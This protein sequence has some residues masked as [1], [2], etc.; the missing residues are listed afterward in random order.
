MENMKTDS[1]N[2][3]RTRA[4]RSAV[5]AACVHGVLAAGMLGGSLT[6]GA[7]RQPTTAASGWSTPIAFDI[8]AQALETALLLFSQQARIQ[9]VVANGA[10]QGVMAPALKGEYSA[11]DALELLLSQSRLTYEVRDERTIAI[12]SEERVGF[13]QVSLGPEASRVRVAQAEGAQ[14]SPMSSEG[15]QDRLELEEIIVTGSH[16]RG[17]KV[18]VPMMRFTREEIDQA[19][20]STVED[21]FES[22]PQNLGEVS[23]AAAAGTGVSRI[24]SSNT[25]RA[26]GISLR[27][28][29]PESTLVLLNGKRR[30]GNINGQVFDISA[31]PLSVIERVEVVTGGRSA[32]YGADAV[33][34]VVNLTTRRAFNGAESQLYYGEAGEGGER[35]QASQIFG[36]EGERGGF[37]AAYDY[38]RDHVFDLVA[39]TDASH[40]PSRL[41][42]SLEAYSLI[43]DRWRHSGFFSGQYQLTENV[44]V[45]GDAL[46][47]DSRNKAFLTM[48]LPPLPV[49]QFQNTDTDSEQYSAVLGARFRLGDT[50]NLDV[51]GLH[52]IVDNRELFFTPSGMDGENTEARLSSFSEVADGEIFSIGG[53]SIRAALGAEV[54]E[55]SYEGVPFDPADSRIDRER[56][57]TSLFG[58]LVVPIV[59]NARPG[60][61]ELELSLAA[62]YDDYDD[63]GD[64]FN[65]QLGVIWQPIDSLTLRGAYS[66][67]YRAPSLYMLSFSGVSNQAV[68]NIL[69]DPFAPGGTSP[70][71]VLAGSNPDLEPEE[72]KTWSFGVDYEPEFAR[73]ASLSISWFQ[74]EYEG[75]ID[76]PAV[77]RL[78]VLTTPEL[79]G[80]LTNRNPDADQ[81]AQY[82]A[83]S[84]FENGTNVPFDPNTQ[85]LLDVFPNLVVFDNRRTN[86][87]E[88]TV[89]G[90]DFRLNT[91]FDTDFGLLTF[92]LNG[93]HYLELDRR[94]TPTSPSFQQFDRPGHPVGFQFRANAGWSRSA[95]SAFVFVHYADDYL[96]MEVLPS[97]KIDS[98]TTTDVT[99]RFDSSALVDT[100]LASGITVTFHVANV[101]DRE[102]PEFLSDPRGLGYDPAN[103][104]ALGRVISLRLAKSW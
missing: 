30:P 95:F 98:F 41:G 5:R 67:A 103:A 92:G 25:Q 94:T 46:Y 78:S 24:A 62:R 57:V 64:T 61:R 18:A 1:K 35:F 40:S 73:W 93:T 75:R 89:R 56:T 71:L 90:L 80:H 28:L 3:S 68:L 87:S 44:E 14:P 2:T 26:H 52:G 60:L 69:P 88:Q 104:S 66:T 85:S 86:I 63:F 59:R 54:R 13:E 50:W 51:S 102:P 70:T 10:V 65:P 49:A 38:A 9:V 19:G 32:T 6:Y 7:D 45:Y 79:Y 20:F 82:L 34:G 8:P 39:D 21:F 4:L 91:R 100:G 55:E 83:T 101:F 96:D 81:L 76:Q 77:N 11:M 72:A 12:R 42:L 36:V 99:L 17:A 84:R 47:T 31:I 74:I 22:L 33:A 15:G 43:P 27:G 58:E 29:G 23:P 48:T 16:I 97:R 53:N 37:I